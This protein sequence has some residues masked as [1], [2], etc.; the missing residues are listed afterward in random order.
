MGS[1]SGH[2]GLRL[3]LAVGAL[4][5]CAFWLWTRVKQR[6]IAETLETDLALPATTRPAAAG[7]PS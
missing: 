1:L 6:R 5:S 4:V 7:T 3:P 2:F